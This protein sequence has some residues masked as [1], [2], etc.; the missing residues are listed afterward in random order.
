MY[1]FLELDFLENGLRNVELLI[2]S[3][4]MPSCIET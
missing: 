4:S 3:E 1:I 2:K